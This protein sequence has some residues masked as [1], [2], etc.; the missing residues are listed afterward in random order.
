MIQYNL[1]EFIEQL[2]IPDLDK[3]AAQQLHYYAFSVIC[4]AIE[5]MGASI[6]NSDLGDFALC[7]Q[8]FTN[9]LAEF[10]KD[11]RYR[12]NQK[13]FFQVLRGPLIHQ[14]RPGD[15]FFLASEIKDNI[16]PARHLEHHESGA[17]LL[18]IE[19]FL[20]DFKHAFARFKRHLAEKRAP[21]PE[22]FKSTFLVVCPLALEYGKTTW[23]AELSKS[24]TLTP[25]ATGSPPLMG[26][27][28]GHRS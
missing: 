21:A 26:Q 11:Q 6:D 23:D 28:D 24:V 16:D 7:E 25:A 19:P 14:L 18:I 1:P 10:F 13:K 15:G 27:F 9:A 12:N 3:M 17:T 2:V 4:Q 20:Q 8:R 5:V 22:R